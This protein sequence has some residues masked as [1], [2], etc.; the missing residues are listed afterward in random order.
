MELLHPFDAGTAIE[1]AGPGRW[2]AQLHRAWWIFAGP[3]GGYVAA[4]LL[5]AMRAAV[6]DDS[7]FPRS[8]TIHYL[9]APAEGPLDVA[10]TVERSGRSVTSVSLRAQQGG[11]VVALAAG[12]FAAPIPG[13][14]YDETA[15][16][17]VPPAAQIA[18]TVP[19]PGAAP[20]LID[21]FDVRPV[22]G[23]W[24]AGRG[25]EAVIGAWI[26]LDP[27]RPLD[28][29][30]LAILADTLVPAPFARTGPAAAPTVELTLHYRTSDPA[31]LPAAGEHVLVVMRAPLSREGFF[32]EDAEIWSPDG[33]LLLQARQLA[34]LR[35]PG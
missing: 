18:R 4:I 13:I 25:E 9:R 1:P 19:P 7:R 29:L 31:A 8:V 17:T 35:A 10:V 21:N 2:Q 3:N 20:P 22:I 30:A 12:A 15:M 14:A 5:R 16:P 34:L 26:R 11:K 32:S 6:A 23:P 27:S 28:A 33:T 24:P